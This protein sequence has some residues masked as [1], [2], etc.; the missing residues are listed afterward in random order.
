M[1]K[2]VRIIADSMSEAFSKIKR[3]FGPDAMITHQS[4]QNGKV[5]IMIT[6]PNIS[7]QNHEVQ[8]QR[9]N[10]G[11]GL[12]N[13]RPYNPEKH[14]NKE[15]LDQSVNEWQKQHL[16]NI[17]REDSPIIHQEN[18]FSIP[19]SKEDADQLQRMQKVKQTNIS[20]SIEEDVPEDH[21]KRRALLISKMAQYHFVDQILAKH[22]ISEVKN[23]SLMDQFSLSLALTKCI[24]FDLD[25][26]SFLKNNQSSKQFIFLGPAGSGKTVAIAK[27]AVMLSLEGQE[28]SVVSLDTIKSTGIDQLRNYINPLGIDLKTGHSVLQKGATDEIVLIDTPGMN[29]FNEEDYGYIRSLLSAFN[30]TPICVLSAEHNPLSLDSLFQLWSQ[31]QIEHIMVTKLDM[32]KR[33]GT[34]LKSGSHDFKLLGTSDSPRIASPIKTFNAEDL[35]AMMIRS[36]KENM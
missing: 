16:T 33:F 15:H 18:S 24:S 2:E 10:G 11:V 25:V 32:V 6:V 19:F 20:K 13:I 9:V 12:A 5:E 4:E 26:T 1:M 7:D 14:V 28:F 17:E 8:R 27:L 21:L 30:L 35:V 36:M 3:D 31:L 23:E 22:W 34:V 29:M